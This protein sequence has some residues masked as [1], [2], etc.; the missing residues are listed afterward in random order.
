MSKILY[1]VFLMFLAVMTIAQNPVLTP[2]TPIQ[3]CGNPNAPADESLDNIIDGNTATKYLNLG[4]TSTGP[5]GNEDEKLLSFIVDAGVQVIVD[6]VSFTTANDHAERDPMILRL[7]GSNDGVEFNNLIANIDIN[8]VTNRFFQQGYHFENEGA[9]RYYKFIFR[10]TCTT[11]AIA[12]QLAETQLYE[13]ATVVPTIGQW[14]LIVLF[15]LLFIIG[16]TVN[17]AM[18]MKKTFV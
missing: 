3:V 17:A 4:E 16:V 2:S 1:S 18:K 7:Y 11:S 13:A 8:C 14:A 15:L 9:Y 5:I 12:M 6:S 10:Q